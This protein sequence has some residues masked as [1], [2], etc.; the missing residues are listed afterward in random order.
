MTSGPLQEVAGAAVLGCVGFVAK[1]RAGQHDSRHDAFIFCS[2]RM[3]IEFAYLLNTDRK[4]PG[5]LSCPYMYQILD[6]LED[7]GT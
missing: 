2:G 4:L 5:N 3:G 1:V 6:Y 7:L